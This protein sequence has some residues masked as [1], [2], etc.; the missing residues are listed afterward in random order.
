[1]KALQLQLTDEEQI[2]TIEERT[3][4]KGIKLTDGD[5]LIMICLSA[6]PRQYGISQSL[7]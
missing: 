6:V 5:K 3:T 2:I 7:D 1:M 4:R